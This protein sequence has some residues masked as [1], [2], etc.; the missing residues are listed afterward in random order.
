M[1]TLARPRATSRQ[2]L[3]ALAASACLLSACLKGPSHRS[4][5]DSGS[6]AT[7]LTL[8]TPEDTALELVLPAPAHMDADSLVHDITEGP[9][10]G[11]L[12]ASQPHFV[13]QPDDDFF[14]TDSFAYQ[15]RDGQGRQAQARV[16]INVSPAS[17]PPI[18]ATLEATIPEDGSLHIDVL[19]A[20]LE[21]D[22]DEVTLEELGAPEKGSAVIDA[23]GQALYVPDPDEHGSDSLTYVVTDSEGLSASGL[24]EITITPAA[25]APVA[26]DDQAELDE[27]GSLNL[28]V[29]SNDSDVDDDL[30]ELQAVGEP[31]HGVAAI[32]AAGTI[33]YTPEADYSGPDSFRYT[34]T[35]PTGLTAEAQVTLTIAPVNDAPVANDQALAAEYNVETTILLSATDVDGDS[36]FFTLLGSPQFGTFGPIVST[37][38]TSAQVT[39][40]AEDI[41]TESITVRASD[42]GGGLDTSALTID[43]FGLNLSITGT[44]NTFDTETGELNG[45]TPTAWNGSSLVL[46]AFHMPIGSSLE[47]TGDQPFLL[48][49]DGLVSIDGLIDLSGSDGGDAAFAGYYTPGSGGSGGPGGFPGGAGGGSTP[50]GTGL[51]DGADGMGPGAGTAGLITGFE[52]GCAGGGGGAA[53]TP[54]S[55]GMSWLGG[56]G[57][58]G[59]LAYSGLPLLQAGS[60]GGGG[61]VE[62]DGSVGLKPADDAGGGGGGGGGM[63][64]ILSGGQ[65]VIGASAVIDAAG[66]AGGSSVLGGAGAGGAGG[67]IE[68]LG[69]YEPVVSGTLDVGGGLGGLGY[70]ACHGGHGGEGVLALGLN[71]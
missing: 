13:Y 3:V 22:G 26:N 48:E 30:L 60:G 19:S 7:D 28:D 34:V 33:V 17:D 35:D 11:T 66:G 10:A 42:G 51:V 62:Q 32:G 29:L 5:G 67:I 64:S 27:D 47:V 53:F 16:T 57:G 15:V 71:Q 20:I 18:A 69:G 6:E 46:G 39:Y 38:P 44:G 1:N 59:G 45:N 8:T 12:H 4:D 49:V 54:G 68:L 25:D 50:T 52:D 40:L 37:G 63:L 31:A 36:V 55:P 61:S 70:A 14:G 23:D 65:I 56:Y 41:G 9:T 21:V 43:A 58:E 24:I 2:L